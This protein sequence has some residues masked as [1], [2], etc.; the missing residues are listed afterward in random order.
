MPWRRGGRFITFLILGVDV[1]RKRRRPVGNQIYPQELDGKQRKEQSCVRRYQAQRGRQ[2]HSGEHR[3]QFTEVRR[4]K[5][6]QIFLNVVIDAAAF[7][8][9][10]DDAGEVVVG[11]HH[12]GRFLGDVGSRDAH[13]HTDIRGLKSRGIVDAVSGHGNDMPFALQ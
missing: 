7:L 9:R 5:V 3:E 4:Q 11:Q 8:D 2:H 12:V 1:E 13:G 6:D 10:L